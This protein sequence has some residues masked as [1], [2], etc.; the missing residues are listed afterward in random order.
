MTEEMIVSE[1][2]SVLNKPLEVTVMFEPSRL[3]TQFLVEAYAK[4]VPTPK[5]MTSP[6]PLEDGH[7]VQGKQGGRG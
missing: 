4:I 5:R 6:P 1:R 7:Y 2:M 3:A